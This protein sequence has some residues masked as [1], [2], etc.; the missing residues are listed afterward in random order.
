MGAGKLKR[1]LALGN[2]FGQCRRASLSIGLA[3]LESLAPDF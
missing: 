2:E 1:Q 3:G